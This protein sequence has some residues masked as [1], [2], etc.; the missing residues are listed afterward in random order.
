M[1]NTNTCNKYQKIT[2]FIT[3]TIRNPEPTTSMKRLISPSSSPTSE[4]EPKRP[5]IK[6][7]PDYTRM[8]AD[9]LSTEDKLS[10]EE[11]DPTKIAEDNTALQQAL[12]P[13]I[14]YQI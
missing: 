1:S 2:N 12:G 11:Q 4:H 8:S 3:W 5:N 14:N 7:N 9:K 10:S 13:L 6:D